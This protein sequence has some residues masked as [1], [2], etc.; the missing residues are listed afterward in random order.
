A[1]DPVGEG[2]LFGGED[3]VEHLSVARGANPGSPLPSGERGG[4]SDL[5]QP[6]SNT[7]ATKSKPTTPATA[8]LSPRPR[9]QPGARA[10]PA[11][12]TAAASSSGTQP[13]AS[14]SASFPARTSS[15]RRGHG[16]ARISARASRNP[17]APPSRHAGIS[18]TP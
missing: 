10:T 15:S 14:N 8:S 17:A 2:H 13:A 16:R 7:Y 1:G 18:R 12:S 11:S 5:P 4:N 3:F 9:N 6:G